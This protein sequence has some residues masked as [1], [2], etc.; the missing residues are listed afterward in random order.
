[1]LVPSVRPAQ[2]FCC[3]AHQ[4]HQ[5]TTLA[6]P[7]EP[8]P[9]ISCFLIR[10]PSPPPPPPC[11][12]CCGWQAKELLDHLESVLANEPVVVKSGH[13]IV[14]VKPQVRGLGGKEG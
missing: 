7:F 8:I 10:T 14:E 12:F 1:M 3:V 11:C 9:S 4:K 2:H 13:H 5:A 6:P